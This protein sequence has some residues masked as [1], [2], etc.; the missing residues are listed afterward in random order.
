MPATTRA[1][2][3]LAAVGAGLI[4]LALVSSAPMLG[5]VLLAAIGIVEFAWGVLVLFDERFLAPR[6]AAIAALAPI[7]V[8]MAAIVLDIQSFRVAPLAVAA[9][10]E[11]LI[12]LAV[13]VSLRRPSAAPAPSTR[14][15]ALALLAGLVVVGALTA[16]GLSLSGAQGDPSLF[17][18]GQHH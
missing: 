3:A 1:W 13:A 11:L 16:L 15:Y 17:A 4:H 7:A 9:V 14:R 18:P 12:A 8:W 5:A 10:L 6:F 2:V